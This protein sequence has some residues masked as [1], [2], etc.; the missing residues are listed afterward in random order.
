MVDVVAAPERHLVNLDPPQRAPRTAVVALPSPAVCAWLVPDLLEARRRS[1]IDDLA[2]RIGGGD[3]PAPILDLGASDDEALE[4]RLAAL[5]EAGVRRVVLYGERDQPG[6]AREVRARW[7]GEVH[8]EPRDAVSWVLHDE[9]A[10]VVWLGPSVARTSPGTSAPPGAEVVLVAVEA[11]PPAPPSGRAPSSWR[12]FALDPERALGA[13]AGVVPPAA[14]AGGERG[15]ALR[16]AWA[17]LRP[18]EAIRD[19]VLGC[20]PGLERALAPAPADPVTL[21]ARRFVVTGTDGSG[22]STHVARLAAALAADGARV[23]VAKIYRQG[24]FLELADELSGRVA[25]GAPLGAFRLSRVVKLVDSLRTL[26]GVLVS[27]AARSDV[28]LLDRWT[29]T[30]LAAARSQLGWDL[31]RHPALTAFPA[32]DAVAWLLLPP[33]VASERLSARGG[34][35]TADE[36]PAGLAGY[37]EAFDAAARGPGHLRIDGEEAEEENAARIRAFF[38]ERLRPGGGEPGPVP[39]HTPHAV[40]A[41]P[42]SP[43][44]VVVGSVAGLPALGVEILELRSL[45]G[46]A[47]A[48][49]G[50]WLEAWAAQALL[51][52]RTRR[53]ARACAPLWP[54]AAAAAWPDLGPI[55]ELGRL[56]ARECEVVGFSAADGPAWDRLAPPAGARR[57]RLRHRVALEALAADAGWAR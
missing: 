53:P 24:A 12:P 48:P 3:G 36:H 29:E 40:A 25:R 20:D 33:A 41:R 45:A 10:P 5:A 4:A 26:R 2:A 31:T 14:A 13:W 57:L 55:A 49:T 21:P 1:A 39:V 27:A 7:P 46:L 44:E 23:E 47:A 6:F 51:D 34:R 50:F 42:P 56:V 8:S 19:A 37:A 18:H 30:H 17:P 52:L 9:P 35:L 43:C 28:L 54:A 32:P 22:K 11:A 15:R 16:R 38:T